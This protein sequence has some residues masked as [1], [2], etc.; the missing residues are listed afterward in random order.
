VNDRQARRAL[1]ALQ[2]AVEII[3]DAASYCDDIKPA[4]DARRK[5]CERLMPILARADAFEADA[6]M[7]VVTDFVQD[8]Q[9]NREKRYG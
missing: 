4:Q 2:Q 5:I 9:A 6:L 8:I 3:T 7:A 1:N